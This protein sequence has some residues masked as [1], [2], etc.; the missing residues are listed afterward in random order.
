MNPTTQMR[1]ELLAIASRTRRAIQ[2]AMFRNFRS[3]FE[4]WK[5]W[6]VQANARV[7]N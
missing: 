4:I 6:R 7:L 3:T 5:A 1:L 2:I